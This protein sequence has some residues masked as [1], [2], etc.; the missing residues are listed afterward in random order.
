[1]NW[2]EFFLD[3]SKLDTCE[4]CSFLPKI[5]ASHLKGVLLCSFTKSWFCFGVYENI[6]SCSVVR[7]SH[8]FSHYLHLL[9]YLSP[10]PDYGSISSW[11]DEGP[12][13][14]KR[15]VL[16]LVSCPNALWLANSLDCVSVLPHPLPKQHVRQYC[17]INSDHENMNKR[18]LQ[19]LCTHGY[20]K[21][22]LKW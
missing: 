9:Q 1:M 16:W 22:Y 6:L 20:C 21:T 17:H 19:N 11:F 15:N 12:P 3:F 5:V 2:R 4:C 14:E 13:S 18:I 8:Y 7:K 10:Q